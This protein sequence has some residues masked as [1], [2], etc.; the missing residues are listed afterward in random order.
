MGQL[1]LK[2]PKGGKPLRRVERGGEEKGR[3]KFVLFKFNI[4]NVM[5]PHPPFFIFFRLTWQIY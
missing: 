4:E 5:V 1:I 3:G 2:G